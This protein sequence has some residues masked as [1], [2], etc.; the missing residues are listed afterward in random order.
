MD[1]VMSMLGAC[2][3]TWLVGSPCGCLEPCANRAAIREPR[4]REHVGRRTPLALDLYEQGGDLSWFDALRAPWQPDVV[5]LEAVGKG[6]RLPALG[7]EAA[8][9]LRMGLEGVRMSGKG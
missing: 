3:A 7:A 1:K 6:V 8:D 2:R 4:G 5:E 9:D